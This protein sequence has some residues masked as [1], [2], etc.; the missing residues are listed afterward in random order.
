MKMEMHYLHGN[1]PRNRVCLSFGHVY[2]MVW[3]TGKKDP[4]NDHFHNQT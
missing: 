1:L 2:G 4:L 3:Q